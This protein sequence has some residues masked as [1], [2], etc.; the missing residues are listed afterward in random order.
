[1]KKCRVFVGGLVATVGTFVT[2]FFGAGTADAYITSC[3]AAP[4]SGQR[5]TAYCV[6]FVASPIE[7]NAVRAVNVCSNGVK[8][9]PWDSTYP[10]QSTSPGCTW[11]GFTLD[12]WPQLG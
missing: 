9:G 1:M 2:S 10:Y 5:V 4:I 6:S 3:G 11:P 7:P 8:L 12:W